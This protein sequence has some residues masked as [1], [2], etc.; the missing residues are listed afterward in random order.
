[1]EGP[2]SLFGD[3]GPATSSDQPQAPPKPA[4]PSAAARNGLLTV[5]TLQLRKAAPSAN[6]QV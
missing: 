4:H 6:P 5:D 2:N 1:M 3:W